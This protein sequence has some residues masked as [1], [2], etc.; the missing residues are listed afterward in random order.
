MLFKW[1]KI[2]QRAITL[3]NNAESAEQVNEGENETAYQ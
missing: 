3:S 2:Y 1:V